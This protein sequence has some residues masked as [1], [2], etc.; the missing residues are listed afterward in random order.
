MTVTAPETTPGGYPECA[1]G[2]N[3]SVTESSLF[4]AGATIDPNGTLGIYRYYQTTNNGT[5]YIPTT[6]TAAVPASTMWAWPSGT[7]NTHTA[8]SYTAGQVGTTG[9]PFYYGREV[10]TLVYSSPGNGTTTVLNTQI[11]YQY[12]WS[13]NSSQTVTPS[14]LFT[15]AVTSVQAVS[16]PSPYASPAPAPLVFQGDPPRFTVQLND[17]YP[18]G[19]TSVIIYPGTPA[20]NPSAT[21]SAPITITAAATPNSGLYTTAPPITFE[22]ASYISTSST[23][24]L[25]YTIAAVQTL[26]SAYATS[27]SN[28]TVLNTLTFTTTSGFSVNGTVGTVK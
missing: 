16:N 23:A 4:A 17:L 12:P 9:T 2:Y 18:N 21:G 27:S 8:I 14:A 20:S 5:S 28:P 26:P 24:P 10:L 1:P 3:Y 19:A 13:Y 7:T 15:N 11:I 6:A 25:T 22:V